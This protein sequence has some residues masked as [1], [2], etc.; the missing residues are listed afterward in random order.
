MFETVQRQTSV[1]ITTEDMEGRFAGERQIRTIT[2]VAF[3]AGNNA[4]VIQ[5]VMMASCAVD[6]YVPVVGKLHL[7]STGPDHRFEQEPAGTLGR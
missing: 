7:N 3:D 5:K 2:A 1:A 4:S 6:R